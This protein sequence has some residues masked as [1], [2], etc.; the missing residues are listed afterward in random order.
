M[1]YTQTGNNSIFYQSQEDHGLQLKEMISW[2][3]Q[4]RLIRRHILE[5]SQ[6]AQ[7]K[8]IHASLAKKQRDSHAREWKDCNE[9]ESLKQVV[10]FEKI[11]GPL[12]QD[13]VGL[14]WGSRVRK[15]LSAEKEER[16]AI[17]RIFKEIKEEER[18]TSVITNL[19]HFGEWVKWEAA[20]QLDRRWH[21]LLAYESDA[22]IRFRLCATED[23]L[24]T[25][26]NLKRWGQGDGMCP[27]GC[28]ATG[29]L[30]HL[31]C[32]CSLDEKPQ[33]R[34]TWRHDSVLFAIFRGVLA[35]VNRSKNSQSE[36]RLGRK[37]TP[38]PPISF[39][40]ESDTKFTAVR[41]P[42]VT[43]LLA[44]AMDWKLQF[45]IHAPSHH[46]EKDRIFPSEIVEDSKRPD[47]VIWSCS[48]KIVIWIELTCPWE[49]NMTIRHA[50]KK[51]SYNQLRINCEAKG[52]KVYPLCVEVG[53]RG[54]VAQSF[55]YMCK[56]LGFTKA[57][58][59]ELKFCLE[60][61]AQHCSHAI[62]VHRY[63]KQWEQKPLLDISKWSGHQ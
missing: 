49:E 52:W 22:S 2:H 53:C 21:C 1:G 29:S 32:G 61:T 37:S 25:P 50:Q 55:H 9:I 44:T 30:R 19:Q 7:V 59:K 13:G 42:K 43:E 23:M 58:E 31:L 20:M 45:D 57:E 18:V 12:K 17:L 11:R 36:E 16:Q 15:K 47:G 26:S 14:G 35:V 28:K 62:F 34:I 6:D 46:Q 39:K 41:A 63:V 56:V 48:S 3:K 5:S 40:S 51:S 38:R 10:L 4:N 54:H 27:L 60:K 8:A 33:S 24:P